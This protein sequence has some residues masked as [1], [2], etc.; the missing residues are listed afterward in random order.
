MIDPATPNSLNARKL[1]TLAA[2]LVLTSP[3]VPMILQAQEMLETGSFSD[4]QVVD[5]TKET[6][7]APILAMYTD[8][9]AMRRNLGG[10]TAGLAGANINVFHTN[11][12]A[13]VFAFH[14]FDAGGPGDDVVVVVNM[15]A[16]PYPQYTIGF[17][18]DGTWKV[19]F[20]GDSHR[21]GADFTGTISN[22][23]TVAATPRDNLPYSG[24]VGVGPYSIVVL[25]Q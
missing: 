13:H 3:G 15:S 23:V 2:S 6:T 17:P 5:W 19:R 20:N 25:S 18:H 21:Y 9:V 12:S 10:T 4:K 24:S 7:N 14:R 11:T 1:S 16:K 22:A 8:L